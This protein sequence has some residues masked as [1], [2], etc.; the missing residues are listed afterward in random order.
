[1]AKFPL[2]LTPDEQSKHSG[3]IAGA[4]KDAWKEV[5]RQDLLWGIAES[6]DQTPAYRLGIL[7][8][9]VGE[10]AKEVIEN[11]RERARKELVQ[12]AA[13]ALSNIIRY[14]AGRD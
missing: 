10:Y 6:Q 7:V 12:V 4:F 2:E 8:E 3:L 1:M 5:R 11:S 14:D 13:V 9:E